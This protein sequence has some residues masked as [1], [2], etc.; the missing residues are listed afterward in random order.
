MIIKAAAVADYHRANPPR[1]EREEDGGAAFAGT[2]SDAR[3]SGRVGKE[4]R[5]PV[6]G[7]L[8]GGDREPD[9]GG[10][11]QTGKQELR[12]GG[13]ES[14][15]SQGWTNR[16][17][18]SDE[19]EVV[20]VKRTGESIPV[21]RAPKRAIARRIFDEMIKLRLALHAAK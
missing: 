18:D 7:R 4:E 19:N 6:A 9:R 16:A 1:A 15:V 5:R 11:A 10:A 8:R 13:G 12:H 20:L 14:G 21:P 2:G 3:Y 17:F